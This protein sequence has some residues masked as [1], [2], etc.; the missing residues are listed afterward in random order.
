MVK[1]PK[2]FEVGY[3]KPP[4]KTRFKEGLS[5][6]PTGRPKGK[7]NL[8]TV[9][10]QA[11]LAKVVVNDGGQ[12]QKRS[13]FAVSITQLVNKAAGG[14]LRAMQILLDLLPL[15]DS[16]GAGVHLPPDLIVDRE[17]ALKLVARLTGQK[18]NKPQGDANE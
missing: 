16:A 6:N 11:L 9:L 12:R 18:L 2:E 14:D 3:G 17:L 10:A 13:K 5:G 1:S 8:S 7:L 15:L 4:I